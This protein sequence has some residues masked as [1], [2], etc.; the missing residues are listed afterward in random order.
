[1]IYRLPLVHKFITMISLGAFLVSVLSQVFGHIEPCQL[2]VI[3]RYSFLLVAV[4]ALFAN[5]L[6]PLRRILCVVLIGSVLFALYHL[7]V[8]N[9]W[10]LGPQSCTTELPSLSNMANAIEDSKVYC[11]RANWIIFGVSSTLWSFLLFAFLFWFTSVAYILDYYLNK[12]D[13]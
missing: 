5:Y 1:M 2:C 6:K 9:H 12:I 3:S 11:D 13:E 8:E 4:L 7:G 10:W